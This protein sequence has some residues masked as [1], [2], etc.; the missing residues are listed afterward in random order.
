MALVLCTGQDSAVMETRQLILEKAGHT[1][2]L[3]KDERGIEKACQAHAFDVVVIGQ[4]TTPPVKERIFQ[5]ART[6]CP[7]TK[8]LELHRTFSQ[9]AL[10]KADAWLE[11]PSDSPEKLAEVV[12]A[13][14]T[15]E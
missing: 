2:I 7:G 9:K 14:A 11:M 1:V 13:L 15:A 3:A 10:P 8:I 6:G 12:T 4:N 5:I